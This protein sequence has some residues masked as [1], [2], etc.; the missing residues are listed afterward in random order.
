M[1]GPSVGLVLVGWLAAP[2]A[3]APAAPPPVAAPAAPP[4]AVSPPVAAPT[5]AAPTPVAPAAAAPVTPT[6]QPETPAAAAPSTPTADALPLG[7]TEGTAASAPPPGSVPPSGAPGLPAT[8]PTDPFDSPGL[9]G[10]PGGNPFAG[11][12]PQV[13]HLTVVHRDPWTPPPT[14]PPEPQDDRL[15]VSGYGGLSVRGTSVDHKVGSLLGV[16]GGLLIGDRLSIGGAF[17]ELTRRY[18]SPLRDTS[19]NPLAIKMAYGGL[20]AAI[21]AIRGDR[22]E[23]EA[24]GLVGAG[25]ACV[26]TDI[27]G[28]SSGGHCIDTVRMFVGQPEIV[29]IVNL[30]NWMRIGMQGGYRFVARQAWRPPNDFRL[31]GGFFGANL[32]FGWFKRPDTGTRRRARWGV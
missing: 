1:I 16:R 27:H 11:G 32:E 6:P 4:A 7:R 5:E 2:G 23:L 29:L 26:S 24:R 14:L 9:G 20:Q 30:T 22:V 13:T 10:S 3:T 21:T 25:M 31:A 15:F 19:G 8:S 18:G 17:Y 12:S 28:R